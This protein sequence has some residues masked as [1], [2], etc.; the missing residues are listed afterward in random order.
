MVDVYIVAGLSQENRNQLK[1]R[2]E[3]SFHIYSESDFQKQRLLF[4]K[5][6]LGSG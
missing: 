3:A 2:V 5:V 1:G 6:F 4:W